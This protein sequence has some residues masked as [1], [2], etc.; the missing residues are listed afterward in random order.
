MRVLQVIIGRS[1]QISTA[2]ARA[3]HQAASIND[4]TDPKHE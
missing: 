4:Q 1:A 3:K 2:Q